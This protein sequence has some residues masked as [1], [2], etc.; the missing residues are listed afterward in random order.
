MGKIVSKV[1][2]PAI[3]GWLITGMA[4]G[5]HAVGIIDDALLSAS[6]YHTLLNVFEVSLGLMIGTELIISKL[7]KS[8]RQIIIT[9][10]TQSLGIFFVVA[11]CFGVIFY[12]TG[13]PLYLAVIFGAIALATA[14]APALSIIQEFRTDGPI[15]KTLMPMAALDDIV[16]IIVFFTATTLIKA[17]YT[18]QSGSLIQSLAVMILLPLAVGAILGFAGSAVLKKHRSQKNTLTLITLLVLTVSAVSIAFN[19]LI[20]QQPTFNFML[21]GLS[22]SATFANI[23][24]EERLSEIL[25]SSKPLLQISLIVVILNLGVPLDYQLIFSAG[26]FT[27]IYIL[28]RALGKYSGAFVGAKITG[29]PDTVQKY[30]GLTLLPHSGVSLVFTGIA[31][32]SISTFDPSSAVILQGTITAA[33]VLNEVI[34]VL[35][36]Y[37]GSIVPL[38]RRM[39]STCLNGGQM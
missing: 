35:V 10:L 5:P 7:K 36:E 29:L 24:S 38:S 32:S 28:S 14:P 21:A 22:F 33:A 30:L 16:A 37:F 26:A 11:F 31:A 1:K 20:L 8:G 34:A 23:V 19:S 27:A 6:W 2:L 25:I 9:T 39:W 13:V 17:S 18:E 3:L 4:L 12:F 15:T